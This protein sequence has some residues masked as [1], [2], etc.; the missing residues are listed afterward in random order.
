MTEGYPQTLQTCLGQFPAAT[1]LEMDLDGRFICYPSFGTVLGEHYTPVNTTIAMIEGSRHNGPREIT[2]LVIDRYSGHLIYLAVAMPLPS[3]TRLHIDVE[4]PYTGLRNVDCLEYYLRHFDRWGH[5][6]SIWRSLKKVEVCIT[7]TWGPKEYNT[8]GIWDPQRHG[9]WNLWV[10]RCL[11]Q[12]TPRADDSNLANHSH[13]SPRRL[14]LFTRLRAQPLYHFRIRRGELRLL[15][16]PVLSRTCRWNPHAPQRIGTD[17][18]SRD[19]GICRSIKS[20]K[21]NSAQEDAVKSKPLVAVKH[22]PVFANAP[23]A[24]TPPQ[25]K[26]FSIAASTRKRWNLHTYVRRRLREKLRPDRLEESLCEP[27]QVLRFLPMNSRGGRS[28]VFA[29]LVS[30]SCL[31]LICISYLAV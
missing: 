11:Y 7:V 1:R 25:R 14:R 2:E 10:S 22:R 12:T 31:A 4:S 3:L 16:A 20:N 15:S 24:S 17:N 19:P 27:I 8:S 18:R 9:T 23:S 30:S 21:S 5:V 26:Q 28:M 6:A 29:V 13:H